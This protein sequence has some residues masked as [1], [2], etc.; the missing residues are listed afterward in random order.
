[1]NNDGD[2][3]GKHLEQ[4]ISEKVKQWLDAAVAEAPRDLSERIKSALSNVRFNPYK[5]DPAG[6]VTILVVDF[7]KDLDHNNASEI[8]SDVDKAKFLMSKLKAKLEPPLFHDRIKMKRA[9]WSAA[10][11][12][13]IKWFRRKASASAVELTHLPNL[14]FNTRSQLVPFVRVVK[15]NLQP[16]VRALRALGIRLLLDVWIGFYLVFDNF[17]P[18]K[19]VS[20]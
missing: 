7:I 16:L 8:H 5:E 19:N 14:P 2:G 9:L 20:I 10:E 6:A 18:I 11:N 15:Q 4:S 3:R 12:R 17:K 13:D 1:M